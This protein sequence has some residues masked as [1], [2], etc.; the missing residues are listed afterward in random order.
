MRGYICTMHFNFLE[1][2]LFLVDKPLEWTSF[3]VVNKLRNE[4]RKIK[5][6][7]GERP[8]KNLKVGHAGTLDPL[9]TGLLIIATG[10]NTKRLDEWQAEEKEY[11]GEFFLGATTPSFDRETSINQNFETSHITQ[12]LIYSVAKGLTGNLIQ[13]PPTHSAIKQDGERVYE[14][15]RRGEEVVMKTKL[16]TVFEFEITTIEL[17]LVSFR[18][19]CSKGTY[20]RSIANDFGKA[21]NSGA[22][23]NKLSR[24]RSGNFKLSDA[25]TLD[26]LIP[27]IKGLH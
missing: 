23:L 1:G 26:R 9:A 10:K 16:I 19:V 5:N 12:D 7:T 4:I 6:E 27:L 3:D 11:T 25:M 22:Y 14:K 24:A 15:A 2:E 13:T 21:L 18:I 8:Y 20:I 17:P